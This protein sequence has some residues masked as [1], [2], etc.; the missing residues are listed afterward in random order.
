MALA[1]PPPVPAPAAIVVRANAENPIVAENRRPDTSHGWEDPEA[2]GPA[3]EGYASEPSVL[4][5]QV[6]HFH[7][8]TEPAA[9]YEIQ[10]YRLGWYGGAGGRLVA[11]VSDLGAPQLGQTTG[12][13]A[14]WPVTDTLQVPDG[15]VSGYY[16]VRFELR[17][18]PQTGRGATTIVVVRAPPSRRAPIL[19]HVPV[20]T[21]EAYNGWGGHS[22]YDSTS[23]LGRVNEVSFERPY[24]PGYLQTFEWEL[25]LVRFLEREGYDVA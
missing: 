8:S 25:Q 15:S 14:G 11:T 6:I 2:S 16:L 23:K 18:G 10:V 9:V 3:I 24:A 1:A 22:L 7:V 19:V 21:W 5:G 4:P 17:S 13:G 12:T 20:N